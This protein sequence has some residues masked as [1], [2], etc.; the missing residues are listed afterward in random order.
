[1]AY[2]ARILFGRIAKVHGY[3]G[4][5]TVKLEK[6]FIENIPELESVFLEIDGIPVPFFISDSEYQ[7]ADILKL[8]FEGYESV[9]KVSEFTGCKIF[10]TS[11]K[12]EE[13]II[14]LNGLSGYKVYKIDNRL[15]GT[16]IDVIENPGQLLMKVRIKK[17]KEILIPLHEDFIIK[18]DNKKKIIKMN[19]PEGLIDLN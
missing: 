11:G 17:D 3:E 8:K 14:D 9:E 19:L 16:V 10:L 18:T 12:T 15:V 4:A 5:V 2:N 1:M 13:N 6:A 7:G